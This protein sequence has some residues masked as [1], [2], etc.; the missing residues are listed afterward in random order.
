[1]ACVVVIYWRVA[2]DGE[3][4]Y[5]RINN[6]KNG[7]GQRSEIRVTKGAEHVVLLALK[8]SA[9]FNWVHCFFL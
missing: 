6:A 1:M 3:R 2:H 8:I 5:T 9:P 7:A 4:L